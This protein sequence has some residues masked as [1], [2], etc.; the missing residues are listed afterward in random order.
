VE[1]HL[2]PARSLAC[3]AFLLLPNH[4]TKKKTPP[5]AIAMVNA[6]SSPILSQ[7][8]CCL[9]GL[10]GVTAALDG[11][12]AAS[13]VCRRLQVVEPAMPSASK[14]TDFWNLETASFVLSV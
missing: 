14:P 7:F 5:P 11:D 3:T 8:F 6:K 4:F 10:A 12:F 9:G 13:A 1:G 2:H